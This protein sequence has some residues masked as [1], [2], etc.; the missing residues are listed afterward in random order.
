MIYS[1]SSIQRVQFPS[2]SISQYHPIGLVICVVPHMHVWMFFNGFWCKV[3][4]YQPTSK[5]MGLRS[6]WRCF[7]PLGRCVPLSAWCPTYGVGRCE[8]TPAFD[9]RTRVPGYPAADPPGDFEQHEIWSDYSFFGFGK[10]PFISGKSRNR[11]NTI[12]F[13]Q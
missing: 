3:N 4:I 6:H 2:I 11:W 8:P 5:P 1:T 7:G 12:P 13:G 9:R 10:I